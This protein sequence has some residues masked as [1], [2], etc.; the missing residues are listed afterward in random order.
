MLNSRVSKSEYFWFRHFG[1][2]ILNTWIT[3][4]DACNMDMMEE[5]K[6]K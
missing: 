4:S 1:F 6:K 5:Y 3:S 2:P